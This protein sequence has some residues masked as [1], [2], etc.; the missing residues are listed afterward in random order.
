MAITW[1]I[2][3][4]T[5]RPLEPIE[6]RLRTSINRLERLLSH[7]PEDALHLQ[8]V[9]SPQRKNGSQPVT[10]NLRVPSDV[11]QVRKEAPTTDRAMKEA[12]LALIGRLERLKSRY[13][14]DHL[15]KG[16]RGAPIPEKVA[17]FT[18]PLAEGAIPQT[19][20]DI[21]SRILEN[22]YERL[23]GFVRRQLNEYVVSGAVPP[24]AIDAKDIAHR[25]AEEALADTGAKPESM[26]YYTWCT[27]LAFK[28]TRD[29]V[30]GHVEEEDR[31]L[32]VDLD[33]DL[34]EVTP[35]GVE[36]EEFALNLLQQRLEPD[37]TTL[38]DTIPDP[39]AEAP[40]VH[41][42]EHEVVSGMRKM[43]RSW[44]TTE[45]Q[46]FEMHFLEGMSVE[47]LAATFQCDR[48]NVEKLL[49]VIRARL[50]TRLTAAAMG[51]DDE[52]RATGSDTF[53]PDPAR[54]AAASKAKAELD[55]GRERQRDVAATRTRSEF[56]ALLIARRRLESSLASAAP[57]REGAWTNWVRDDLRAVHDALRRHRDSACSRDGL[58]AEIRM[59]RPDMEPRVADLVRKQQELLDL[60]AEI[61]ETIT[62]DAGTPDFASIRRQAADLLHLIQHQHFQEVD[63]IY[64]TFWRDLGGSD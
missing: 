22:D 59:A 12:V 37:E 47:D 14:R 28:H 36:P 51:R 35:D 5:G 64:E 55:P 11:L 48:A 60:A 20:E 25:V 26:D 13:R 29:A 32:P 18:D 9:L 45:R 23:V 50:R 44:P 31:A 6:K 21:V 34:D 3:N 42:F 63:L 1:N 10:L 46:M 15:W 39:H 52:A 8:I 54:T 57:Y 30:R 17:A 58:F 38:A 16:R 2:V 49:A 62:E 41:L 61:Q 7:F 4:R 27:S 19:V 40:D 56:D 33:I 43:A 53:R 24:A